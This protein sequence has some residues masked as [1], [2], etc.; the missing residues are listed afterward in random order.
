VDARSDTCFEPVF[1]GGLDNFYRYHPHGTLLLTVRN[2][3]E[4]VDSVNNHKGFGSRFKVICK[5]PG[6]FATHWGDKTVTDDDLAQFYSDH[7]QAVRDFA[8]SHP[9]LTYIEVPLESDET[10]SRLETLT[11][12]PASCWGHANKRKHDAASETYESDSEEEE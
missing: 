5:Q 6:Y 12:I 1:H 10:G 7:V 8:A 11:G 4:W 3:D 9:S 2:V